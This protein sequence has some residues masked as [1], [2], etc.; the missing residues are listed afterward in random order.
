MI[1][2]NI[3]KTEISNNI[4][5]PSLS[6]EAEGFLCK[7]AAPA[8]IAG[9]EFLT[10]KFRLATFNAIC[11]YA[12][13][14]AE[15]M[16]IEIKPT[17]PKFLLPF[18]EKASL[19]DDI[20]LQKKWAKLLV[21]AGKE[22]NSV[23]IQYANILSQISGEEA[24]VLKDIYDIQKVK[25]GVNTEKIYSFDF[26]ERNNTSNLYIICSSTTSEVFS[27]DLKPSFEIV[28][29]LETKGLLKKVITKS[30]SFDYAVY[31]TEYGYRFVE[32]LEGA[33]NVST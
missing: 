13:K 16:G 29:S 14:Y 20:D 19:E 6:K 5:L 28:T 17:P 30:I 18:I 22:Y 12:N 23:Y 8:L 3:Q 2:N 25:K 11:E 7:I 32:A 4:N 26:G 21:E 1:E 27:K 9:T 24:K 15:K 10:V 31:L 33:D